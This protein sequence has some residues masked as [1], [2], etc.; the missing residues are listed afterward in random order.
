MYVNFLGH[1]YFEDTLPSVL[2]TYLAAEVIGNIGIFLS[3][4]NE[5]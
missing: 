2:V 4:S 3:A 5:N 1:T